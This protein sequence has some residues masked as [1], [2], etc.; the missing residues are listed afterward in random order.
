M[1]AVSGQSFSTRRSQSAASRQNIP[2]L[3][4][5]DPTGRSSLPLSL[6][7]RMTS[8]RI[9]DRSAWNSPL[10]FSRRASQVP[11]SRLG[12]SQCLRRSDTVASWA[13]PPATAQPDHP[14]RPLPRRSTGPA[15]LP[16]AFSRLTFSPPRC[17]QIRPDAKCDQKRDFPLQIFTFALCPFPFAFS[18]HK[19]PQTVTSNSSGAKRTHRAPPPRATTCYKKLQFHRKASLRAP[20][21]LSAS[22]R[23]TPR[24]GYFSKRTHR[25]KTARPLRPCVF[26]PTDAKLPSITPCVPGSGPIGH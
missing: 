24:P 21:A 9:W 19:A 16:S 7:R 5:C 13:R 15:P 26:D 17:N 23:C 8:L 22:L 25:P 11:S 3:T 6:R 18:R 14:A 1:T 20:S 2:R 4:W 12:F 10:W